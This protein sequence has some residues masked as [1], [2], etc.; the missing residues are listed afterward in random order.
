MEYQVAVEP[1]DIVVFIGI[2]VTLVLG[3]YN[4]RHNKKTAFINT[5]T[6]E[7]IKWIGKL[8]DNISKLFS[9]V[10]KWQR[11]HPNDHQ[12]LVMEIEQLKFEIRLQLNGGDPEDIDLERLI[13][14][15]PDP[16][17]SMD[18]NEFEKL[19]NL[20]IKSSQELLKREWEKVKL[21]SQKGNISKKK[22]STSGL[23]AKNIE[24][25]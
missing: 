19:R 10:D 8:R 7:R 11:Y 24:P 17:K 5:V 12:E 13:E 1:K 2:V 9:L 16:R 4:L 6:S 15:L 21:E 18:E 14:R 25:S 22:N 3:L 20:I 23:L